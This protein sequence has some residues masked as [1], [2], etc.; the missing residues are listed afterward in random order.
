MKLS[1]TSNL[2]YSKE[3]TSG[4]E[5]VVED[6]QKEYECVICS[7]MSA[8]EEDR[9]VGMVVLLQA[10]SVAGHYHQTPNRALPCD[11]KDKAHLKKGENMATMIKTKIELLERYFNN[12]YWP[13]ALNIGW[14]GGV[15]VQTCGHYL[16]IDCHKAYILSL[17][18][19][20]DHSLECILGI[21]RIFKCIK[22]EFIASWACSQS[23][24]VSS[25]QR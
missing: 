17:K 16:H 10:T 21:S 12:H 24:V 4:I 15:H 3:G 22:A 18:M 5:E 25:S 11:E 14:E 7:Q 2:R 20:P 1:S 13:M 6:V 8:S 19:N 23:S 9:P